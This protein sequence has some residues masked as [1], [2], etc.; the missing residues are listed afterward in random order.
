MATPQTEN[1]FTRLADELLDAL[2]RYPFTKR[3]YKVLL[4]VI[5][6]TYGFQKR[7][8]DI[9]ASQLAAMTGLDRANV[10]RVV[11]ELVKSEVLNRRA[12]HYGQLLG[13]NND[14]ETW[15]V[16][17]Q[18]QRWCQNDTGADAKTAPPVVPKQHQ[19][20][21][22]NDTGA[23]AKM[24]PT[25]DNNQKTILNRQ[26][27]QELAGEISIP[28]RGGGEHLVFP[29][30]MTGAE[31]QEARVLITRAGNDAQVVLDVLA[32]A[33]Q[34]GEIRKSRLAVLTGLIRRHEAG[35]FDPAPGLHL[36]D[37]RRRSAAVVA[38]E[39]KREQA[40]AKR[41]GARSHGNDGEGHAGFQQLLKRL[42]TRVAE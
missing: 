21:C 42:K 23:G 2:I 27:P 3:Q 9:S 12:G 14:C 25:I 1:G 40:Y 18:H 17:K 39:R 32:A 16:P 31:L 29:R 33:I 5:R 4:A 8:D 7:E 11:N 26:P 15:A 22:Q 19:R 24:T 41:L 28:P 20:W 35:T 6:K 13:I 10:V 36:A 37:R 34:A 38:A 30:E